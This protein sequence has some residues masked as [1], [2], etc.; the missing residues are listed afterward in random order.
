MSPSPSVHV[1]YVPT[2]L[3]YSLIHILLSVYR[4]C[5]IGCQDVGKVGKQRVYLIF[6]PITSYDGDGD[7][8][9]W[10][11]YG[12]LCLLAFVYGAIG[13]RRGVGMSLGCKVW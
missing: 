9:V 7:G 8:V 6:R 5:L 3:S 10:D 12:M 1:M 2:Y 13:K 11:G 4:C